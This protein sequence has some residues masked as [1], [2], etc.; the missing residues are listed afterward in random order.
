MP[1]SQ[2]AFG[3]VVWPAEPEK[4]WAVIDELL[5]EGIPLVRR[6]SLSPLLTLKICLGSQPRFTIRPDP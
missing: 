4:M 3:T 6:F 5:E 1:F 2:I